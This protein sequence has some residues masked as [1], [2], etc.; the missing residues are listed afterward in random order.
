MQTDLRMEINNEIR[1]IALEAKE[2]AKLNE[3]DRNAEY[4]VM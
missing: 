1:E 3:K 2:K 4:N